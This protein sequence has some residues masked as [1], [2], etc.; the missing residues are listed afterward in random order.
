MLLV[1]KIYCPAL[2]LFAAGMLMISAGCVTSGDL[3]NMRQS[4]YATNRIQYAEQKKEMDAIKEKVTELSGDV[5][6]VRDRTAGAV[7]ESSVEALRESQTNLVSRV[8]ELSKDMQMLKGR[9]E[10]SKFTTDKSVKDI[11]TEREL[12]ASRIAALETELKD[13]K[14]KSVQP[15]EPKKDAVPPVEVK[16]DPQQ[17]YDDAQIAMEEKNFADARK[18]FETI[19]KEFPDNQLTPNAQFWTGEAF[20]AEKKYE[21]SVLAYEAFLKKYPKHDKARG[22]MLKQGYAFIELNDKKTAKVILERLIEKYPT[23]KEAKAA[24]KKLA[25]MLPKKKPAAPVKKKT[26]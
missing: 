14:A 17:L 10:E 9:F 23:S 19:V 16:V 12:L 24:E 6:V 13:L 8:N 7:K 18:N 4:I 5:A 1:R 25:D 21:E 26:K 15:V 3:E 2:L 11:S 20:Y 22:A